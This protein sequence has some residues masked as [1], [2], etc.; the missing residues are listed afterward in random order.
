MIKMP[1]EILLIALFVEERQ[2][3]LVLAAVAAFLAVGS[4]QLISYLLSMNDHE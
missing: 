4:L 1:A 3:A 2:T